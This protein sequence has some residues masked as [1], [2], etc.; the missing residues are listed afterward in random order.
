MKANI[1][2]DGKLYVEPESTTE[3]FALQKW[4]EYS[5]MARSD[6]AVSIVPYDMKPEDHPKLISAWGKIEEVS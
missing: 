5:G 2:G 1:G 3:A 6:I 4:V